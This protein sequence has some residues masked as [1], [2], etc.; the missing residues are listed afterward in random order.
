MF[1]GLYNKFIFTNS[2]LP[3]LGLSIFSIALFIIN[4]KIQRDLFITVTSIFILFE[5]FLFLRVENKLSL[6]INNKFIISGINDIVDLF[7]YFLC[8][9]G[10]AIASKKTT[11]ISIIL[12]YFVIGYL[13]AFVFKNSKGIQALQDGANLSPGFVVISLIPFVFLPSHPPE[14]VS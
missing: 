7:W 5:L 2:N 3:L 8:F 6:S 1:V 12:L 13:S 14:K 9:L 11:K 10:A 4:G